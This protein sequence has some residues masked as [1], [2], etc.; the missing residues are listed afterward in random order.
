MSD[1]MVDTVWSVVIWVSENGCFFRPDGQ[2][3]KARG[4]RLRG[5]CKVMEGSERRKE[6]LAGKETPP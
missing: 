3:A 2:M 5:G 1:S 4:D 6:N